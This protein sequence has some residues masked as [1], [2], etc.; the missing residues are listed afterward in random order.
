MK[1]YLFIL[2]CFLLIGCGKSKDKDALKNIKKKADSFESYNVVGELNMYNGEN[3]YTYNVDVKYKRD[4]LYRV[5][6]INKVNNHEQIILR[7]DDGVYV[8]TH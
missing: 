5:S 6:L 7:N 1:K 3:K 2:L 4:S 8:I